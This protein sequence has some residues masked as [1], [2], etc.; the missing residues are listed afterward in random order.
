MRRLLSLIMIIVSFGLTGCTKEILAPIAE[1]KIE[2]P[3]F[4][5]L[6]FEIQVGTNHSQSMNFYAPAGRAPQL[7]YKVKEISGNPD[8][9]VRLYAYP[10]MDEPCSPNCERVTWRLFVDFS[11]KNP[12]E[13]TISVFDQSNPSRPS[14]FSVTAVPILGKG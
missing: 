10:A 2:L 14:T 3:P 1:D 9:T 7:D 4:G 13:A 12:G 6:S 11:A 8:M 5:W